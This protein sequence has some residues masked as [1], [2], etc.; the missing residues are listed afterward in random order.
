ML[1]EKVLIAHKAQRIFKTLC[2][3]LTANGFQVIEAHDGQKALELIDIEHPDII[4]LDLILPKVSGLEICKS[5]RERDKTREIPIIVVTEKT[6]EKDK[7]LAFERGVDDYI[8][9]PFSTRELIARIKA[10]LRRVQVLKKGRALIQI[11][12]I[13]IDD[14]RHEV[15]VKNELIECTPKEFDL[16]KLLAA[17]P[18]K[19]F[20][21]K[22]LLENIWGYD[23]LGDTRTVD[24]HI[25]HLRQ[26][27]EKI[28]SNPQ[29]IET[30]RGVG[31]RFNKLE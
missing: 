28:P 6:D 29:Y 20:S 1:K 13:I 5:M 18:G 15:I 4:L 26:K 25:H 22:Y 19:V 17:N 12:D 8:T 30:V 9:I 23:Y 14:S 21:R 3:N 2:L 24:V 7:L 27:I 31:Y 16:L 10:V 11:N